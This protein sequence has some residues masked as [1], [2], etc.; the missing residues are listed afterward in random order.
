MPLWTGWEGWV[1]GCSCEAAVPFDGMSAAYKRVLWIVI[2]LNA[3]MFLAEMTGGFV[4]DSQALKA[5][6]LDFLGDAATYSI[7]LAV[8]GGTATARAGAAL[9]KGLSMGALGLFVLGW[10][11]W[12]VFVLGQPNGMV[13]GG[14]A[15]TAFAVNVTAALLL[16]RYRTGDANV[17]S[18]W[19]CSRNDAIG[20]LAVLGAGGLVALTG[21]PWPDLAVAAVIAALF[22]HSSVSIVRHA[23]RDL[24]AARDPV[25][26]ASCAA[27][28]GMQR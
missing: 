22:L 27:A 18:V 24:R 7:T 26:K 5:D 12:R 16:M 20:N 13:M 11:A 3:L 8:I 14:V 23:R 21:T 25:A 4:G 15:L 6:A 1:S 17:R 19:L 2:G 9:F 28:A 10:T